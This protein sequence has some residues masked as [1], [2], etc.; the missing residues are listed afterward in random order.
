MRVEIRQGGDGISCW[1]TDAIAAYVA[2]VDAREAALGEAN[3]DLV[4]T[5]GR[6]KCYGC[7]ELEF[8]MGTRCTAELTR[9]LY[10]VDGEV[11]PRSTDASASLS[12][13]PGLLTRIDAENA[14]AQTPEIHEAADTTVPQ[15]RSGLLGLLG[16]RG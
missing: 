13:I 3:P 7:E 11:A 5:P 16:R 1:N 9:T 10:A 6:L 8:D 14:V 4:V 12:D 2:S 15:R